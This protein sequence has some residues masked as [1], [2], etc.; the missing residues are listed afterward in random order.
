MGAQSGFGLSPGSDL[1]AI[2]MSSRQ[3]RQSM[4]GVDSYRQAH[5]PKLMLIPNILLLRNKWICTDAYISSFS[6]DC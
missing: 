2:L 1:L 3:N 4:D 6:I 5:T